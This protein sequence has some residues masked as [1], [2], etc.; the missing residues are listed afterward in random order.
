MKCPYAERKG[1]I[2]HCK[3]TGKHVNPFT[4]PCISGNYTKCPEYREYMSKKRE[5][6]KVDIQHV[7]V[8]AIKDIHPTFEERVSAKLTDPIYLA[9]LIA[10]SRHVDSVTG[11]PSNI[12]AWGIKRAS[13]LNL[14]TARLDVSCPEE[15][16]SA[17]LVVEDGRYTGAYVETREGEKLAGRNA[18]N[19]IR[20]SECKR[21]VALLYDVRS[22]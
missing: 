17:I 21:A 2:V 7:E 3:L 19:L 16:W 1:F 14:K 5:E 12:L 6:A 13:E 20:G 8:Q 18:W 4:R 11:Q 10:R 9:V 22:S 15:G